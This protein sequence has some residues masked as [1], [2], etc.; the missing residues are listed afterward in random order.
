MQTFNTERKLAQI[1]QIDKTEA[2]FKCKWAIFLVQTS[3]GDIKIYDKAF[4]T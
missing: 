2:I 1:Y 3:S 4:P